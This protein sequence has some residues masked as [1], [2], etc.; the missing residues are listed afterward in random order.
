MDALPTL[1]LPRYLSLNL[2][3][4]RVHTHPYS[5]W[6]NRQ[7]HKYSRT[8]AQGSGPDPKAV[9]R[10]RRV[11]HHTTRHPPHPGPP[12]RPPLRPSAVSRAPQP[13]RAPARTRGLPGP[14]PPAPA[15]PTRRPRRG[16]QAPGTVERPPPAAEPSFCRR[17]APSRCLR[18]P[19]RPLGCRLQP[20][21]RE[22][23]RLAGERAGARRGAAAA[24]PRPRLTWARGASP[25]SPAGS[26]GLR[27]LRG[28][29]APSPGSPPT[30][31][32]RGDGDGDG[33]GTH[34]GTSPLGAGRRRLPCPGSALGPHGLLGDLGQLG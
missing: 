13:R 19:R 21:R 18:P 16:S 5:P 31:S 1:R 10:W 12:R 25:S 2:S 28:L 17:R 34:A 33:G 4:A 23:G 27:G 32:G 20:P 29:H 3:H 9:P 15:A 24:G 14:R 6:T 7:F 30:P 11:P 26:A 22:A 8:Q